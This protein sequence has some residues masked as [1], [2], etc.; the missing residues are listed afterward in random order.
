LCFTCIY[1]HGSSSFSSF[2]FCRLQRKEDSVALLRRPPES[3]AAAESIFVPVLRRM[4]N[5]QDVEEGRDGPM[6]ED[7]FF[8]SSIFCVRKKKKKE[9][10]RQRNSFHR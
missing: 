5:D 1:G 8:S 10:H 6:K 4:M 9:R 2:S 7:F 3:V